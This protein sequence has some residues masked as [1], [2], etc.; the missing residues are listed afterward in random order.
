M[1][2]TRLSYNAYGQDKFAHRPADGRDGIFAD[3]AVSPQHGDV[4]RESLRYGEAGRGHP[5]AEHSPKF[6]QGLQ[7]FATAQNQ[8]MVAVADLKTFRPVKADWKGRMGKCV[9]DPLARAI[10]SISEARG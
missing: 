8:R 5:G 6:P 4:R 10:V 2:M 7:A 3:A 1:D 9:S